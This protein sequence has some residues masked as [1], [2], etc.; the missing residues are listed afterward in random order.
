MSNFVIEYKH[1][2]AYAKAI[3]HIGYIIFDES[4]IKKYNIYIDDDAFFYH[5]DNGYNVHMGLYSR[6]ESMCRV[7][8]FGALD[9]HCLNLAKECSCITL[10]G[11]DRMKIYVH[12]LD[13]SEERFFQNSLALNRANSFYF[14]VFS[15]LHKHIK[16]N[17]S[18]EDNLHSTLKHCKFIHDEICEMDYYNDL[19]ELLFNA[20]DY[21]LP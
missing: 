2:I 12:E 19:M 4:Y 15:H 3:A 11:E 14:T 21:L 6:N 20:D 18:L 16:N 5:H 7:G 17:F 1:C 9:T 8:C 13:D 10:D